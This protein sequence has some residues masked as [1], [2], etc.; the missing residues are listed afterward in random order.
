MIVSCCSAEL[1]HRRT[2]P[3]SSRVCCF[4]PVLSSFHPTTIDEPH[5]L[6]LSIS[7]MLSFLS[8]GCARA[9]KLS[10]PLLP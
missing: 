2:S 4:F 5:R 10:E 8:P 1:L 9:A 6:H 3:P 7:Q